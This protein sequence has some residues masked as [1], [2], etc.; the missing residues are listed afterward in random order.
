[1]PV[2]IV[3]WVEGRTLQEKKKVAEGI[4]ATFGELGLRPDQLRIIMNDVPR[5]NWAIGDKL[6]SEQS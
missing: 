5:T 4:M 1:M 2:V 6:M 3:E